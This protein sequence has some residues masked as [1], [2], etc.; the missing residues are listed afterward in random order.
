M[1]TN[2]IGRHHLH[3]EHLYSKAVFFYINIWLA[4]HR[5]HH[6]QLS[7]GQV[8]V[9]TIFFISPG[10]SSTSVHNKGKYKYHAP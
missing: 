2:L 7:S 3:K 8:A 10:N 6:C 1:P 9:A 5:T 4:P